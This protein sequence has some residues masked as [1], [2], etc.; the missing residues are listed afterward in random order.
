V[1]ERVKE[2]SAD[3]RLLSAL[4]VGAIY[5]SS[6]AA[7][8]DLLAELKDCGVATV[9]SLLPPTILHGR[10][11]DAE[12]IPRRS[13]RGV[14]AGTAVTL[15]N[16]PGSTRMNAIAM[17]MVRPGDFL[18]LKGDQQTAMWGDNMTARCV[19]QGA[20]GAV[21]D[22]VARD[23]EAVRAMGFHLWA[24]RVYAG[25]NSR[26]MRSGLVNV[27]LQ[28]DNA[29]VEPGDVVLADDDGILFLPRPLAEH[30]RSAAAERRVQDEHI[31][32]AAENREMSR[33]LQEI[34]DEGDDSDLVWVG[35]QWT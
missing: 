15:W 5:D 9:A 3:D 24:K 12:G 31:R 7:P 32:D 17:A 13:G 16:P 28:L 27:P 35:D 25:D 26:R 19:A 23:I 21:V 14:V 33:E 29:R 18:I 34:Y 11:L 22:G 2:A 6:P 8:Q 20:V 10:L 4:K 30:L 1:E